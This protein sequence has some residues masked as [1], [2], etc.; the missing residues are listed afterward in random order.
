MIEFAPSVVLSILAPVSAGGNLSAGNSILSAMITPAVLILAASSLVLATSQRLGRTLDRTRLLSEAV[1]KNE[2]K[3]DSR[4]TEAKTAM[5]MDQLHI[6]SRRARLLQEAMLCL[7]L[8]LASLVLTS[9]SLGI[10]IALAKE[11]RLIFVLPSILGVGFLFAASVLLIFES[12]MAFSAVNR[13]MNYIQAFEEAHAV[14]RRARRANRA[15]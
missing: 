7:Y 6:A 2:K 15:A 14:E 11:D 3:E 4:E 12:R 1:E 9:F 5:L 8:S 10:N 13:E